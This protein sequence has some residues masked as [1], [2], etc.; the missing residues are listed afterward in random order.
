[1]PKNEKIEYR[2]FQKARLSEENHE[3]LETEKATFNKSWN[4]FFDEVRKRWY[5]AEKVKRR[6]GRDRQE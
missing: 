3:F 6:E 4:R 2:K 5:E 1:M